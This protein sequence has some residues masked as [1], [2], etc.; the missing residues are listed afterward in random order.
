M[1]TLAIPMKTENYDVNSFGQSRAKLNECLI[2]ET[3]P[4]IK[5]FAVRKL[6]MLTA[7][8]AKEMKI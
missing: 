1:T 7:V 4:R 8:D 2:K 5:H 3:T 6:K